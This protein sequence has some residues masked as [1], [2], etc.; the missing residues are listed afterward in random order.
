[1]IKKIPRWLRIDQ[2][3]DMF[4]AADSERDRMLMKL[5]FYCGLRCS[6]ALALATEDFDFQEGTLFVRNGKG[7]KDRV[8][9][10]P[11]AVIDE[12]KG[13]VRS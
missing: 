4:D 10:I 8:V 6:E 9:P 5:M 12:F 13:F 1:M 2:A 7:G 3:Q 11:K